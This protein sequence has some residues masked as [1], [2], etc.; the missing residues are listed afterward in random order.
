MF[1]E[2]LIDLRCNNIEHDNVHCTE[3]TGH[4]DV[5]LSSLHCTDSKLILGKNYITQREPICIS[6]R[7]NTFDVC[8]PLISLL[9][10]ILKPRIFFKKKRKKAEYRVQRQEIL[11]HWKK[12][13]SPFKEAIG[14]HM[15][16]GNKHRLMKMVLT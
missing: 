8:R 5:L 15:Y 7:L 14:L 10:F 4:L 12:N 13:K 9:A 3:W 16:Y 1:E 11:I 6:H 2:S